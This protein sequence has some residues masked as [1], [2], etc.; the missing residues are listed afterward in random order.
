MRTGFIAAMLVF[1]ASPAI[2]GNCDKSCQ[3]C[4]TELGHPLDANGE[5]IR[6]NNTWG[7]MISWE[8]CLDRVRA[9]DNTEKAEAGAA[10]RSKRR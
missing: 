4:A 7:G 6:R 3:R 2:S 1:A 8:S 5:L 9:Q 10:P